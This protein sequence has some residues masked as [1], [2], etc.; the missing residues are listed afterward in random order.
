MSGFMGG[1]SNIGSGQTPLSMILTAVIVAVGLKLFQFFPEVFA[2][3]AENTIIQGLL[4]SSLLG[5]LYYIIQTVSTYLQKSLKARFW[6]SVTISNKDVNFGVV[7]AFVSKQCTDSTVQMKLSTK[8]QKYTHA[9]WRREYM[10]V[11]TYIYI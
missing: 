11:Y 9:D 3:L 1:L 6:R 4:M 10:G 7:L 8:K 5:M 2:I